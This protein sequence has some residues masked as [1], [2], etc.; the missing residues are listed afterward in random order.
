MNRSERHVVP[1]GDKWKVVAPDADRASA[2]ARTQREAIDRAR[3]IVRNS[4]G[5]EVIIHRPDG[6]IRDSDTVAP[7][8]DPNPPKDKK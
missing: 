6:T 3:E 2:T 1:D 4:G 5:G 7:G 8:N